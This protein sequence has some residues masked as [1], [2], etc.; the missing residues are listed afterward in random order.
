M[1]KR[2]SKKA[3]TMIELLVC[4]VCLGF[5]TVG[6]AAFASA[7]ETN[8]AYVKDREELMLNEYQDVLYLKSN[9]TSDTSS[10]KN[11]DFLKQAE[12]F[13]LGDTFNIRDYVTVSA[14]QMIE[15]TTDNTSVLTVQSG[16]T[17]TA[18]S[19]GVAYVRVNILT[20]GSDGTY[21]DTK[22][23][24]YIPI[25]VKNTTN[26]DVLAELKYYFY[27]GRYYSCWVYGE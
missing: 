24:K 6:I 23:V 11:P 10:L 20:M 3:F 17:C 14:N 1:T 27:G 8:A 19:E 4:L 22:N 15:C 18:R 25:I 16:G 21:H 2:F 12:Q 9:G 5:L 13:I 7:V 26:L